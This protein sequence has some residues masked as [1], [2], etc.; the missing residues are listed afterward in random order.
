MTSVARYRRADRVA[1]AEEKGVLYLAPLPDGPALMVPGSGAS[2]WDAANELGEASA[3]EIARHLA[4]PADQ[5]PDVIAADIA[6][7]LDALVTAR[8]LIRTD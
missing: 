4:G 3:A 7:F 2:V 5:D 6:P 1:S 8:V